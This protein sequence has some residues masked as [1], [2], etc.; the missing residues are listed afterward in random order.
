MSNKCIMLGITGSIAAVKTPAVISML[1]GQ[2]VTVRA[3][4][5]ANAARFVTPLAIRTLTR[6]PV[7]VSLWDEP[8]SW[9]PGHISLA[10]AADLALVAPAD[11]NIIGKLAC[12]IADDAL[13]TE[14]LTLRKPVILAPAMNP[15]MFASPV[16]Q[17]NLRRIRELLPETVIVG[18]AVGPVACGDTGCGRMSEPAE[19]V[20]AVMRLL[21]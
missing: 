6:N 17:D 7:V 10:E 3:V 9:E 5:T 4:M 18:P 2:G 12:G 11:A 1:T 8:E 15:R 13:S 14:L 16:L 21:K 20:D 19:I